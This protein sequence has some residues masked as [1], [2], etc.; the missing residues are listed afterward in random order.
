MGEVIC[1]KCGYM[2]SHLTIHFGN[3]K[4]VKCDN[5]LTV[6]CKQCSMSVCPSCHFPYHN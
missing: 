1:S 6:Y 3:N 4:C 2:N 5:T